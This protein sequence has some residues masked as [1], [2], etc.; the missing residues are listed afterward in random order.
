MGGQ[1]NLVSW[2]PRGTGKTIP[3]DCQYPASEANLTRRDTESLVSINVT[4]RFL[5]GGFEGAAAYAEI[6][7]TSANETGELIG[8]AFTARDM[9]QIIDA[10]GEDGM[11]RYWGLSYG[12]QLGD[13]FA[14]MFPERVE[15]MLLDANMN[16][17]DYQAGHYGDYLRDA[18]KTLEAFLDECIEN[19]DRCALAQFSGATNTSE[20]FDVFNAG[21]SLIAQ[22]ATLNSTA[23]FTY[24]SLKQTL[25]TGLYF[26]RRWPRLADTLTSF[27]NGSAFENATTQSNESTRVPYDL[28][29]NSIDGIRCGDSLIRI[30][31]AEDYLD[32]V[33]YQ[34]TLSP[35]FSDIGFEGTWA[36]AAW[37]MRAREQYT[38]NFTA[39]TRYPILFVNGEYDPATPLVSARNAS[40]GFEGSVVLQHSGYGHGLAAHPSSC[41]ARAVQAYFKDGLLP[42]TRVGTVCEPDVGPWDLDDYLLGQTEATNST[43]RRRSSPMSGED[44]D[45]VQA[46]IKLG[47]LQERMSGLD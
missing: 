18:D 33:E 28:G 5:N 11:L 3:F 25:Y 47:K 21:L 31:R 9:V 44:A 20:L 24:A 2:D 38:G 34:S 37:R 36:C 10:L 26:P 6:C 30:S 45:L 41:V 8:T 39:K 43:S 13:T 32:R 23:Y 1:Y 42:A 14:A 17:H 12:T 19:A 22:N 4:E 16:P 40:A 35:S 29:V 46:M 15:R 7:Y 27:L